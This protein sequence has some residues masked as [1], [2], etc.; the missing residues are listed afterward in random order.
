MSYKVRDE[1]YCEGDISAVKGIKQKKKEGKKSHSGPSNGEESIIQF[2]VDR[3]LRLHFERI[4]H[5]SG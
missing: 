3:M 4:S 5:T 1:F 2:L